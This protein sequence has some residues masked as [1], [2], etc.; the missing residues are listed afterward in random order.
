MCIGVILYLV[1]SK[2]DSVTGGVVGIMNIPAPAFGDYVIDTPRRQYYLALVCLAIGLWIMARITRSL[3][4]RS[5]IAV[6]NS[7]SL[8]QAIGIDLRK[9]K[10]LSFVLSVIYAGFAGALYAGQIRFV[11]P[12]LADQAPTFDQVMIVLV[13]GLGTLLGP[14]VGAFVVTAITQSLQFLQTYRMVVF[15]PFLILLLIF[16]PHGIVGTWLY[17]RRRK[18]AKEQSEA[19]VTKAKVGGPLAINTNADLPIAVTNT[20]ANV[21]PGAANA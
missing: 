7:E 15:G 1:I 14:I 9:T 19:L 11:G 17:Y 6:R 16:V 10:I 8:A 18:A 4:G 3:V 12:E 13:G 21:P 5:F 2:W 20:T